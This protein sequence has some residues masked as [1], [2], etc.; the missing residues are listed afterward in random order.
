MPSSWERVIYSGTF[1]HAAVQEQIDEIAFPRPVRATALR[2][3]PLYVTDAAV[4]EA[5]S[6]TF[7]GF[8]SPGKFALDVFGFD[9]REGDDGAP[10]ASRASRLCP[11][12]RFESDGKDS[13]CVR[14]DARA[15]DRIV[16]RGKFRT[17][18]LVVI[19]SPLEES[20]IEGCAFTWG[21]SV[22]VAPKPIAAAMEVDADDVGGEAVAAAA[23]RLISGEEAGRASPDA[24]SA[25]LAH[26]ESTTTMTDEGLAQLKSAA[27]DCLSDGTG[28][29]LQEAICAPAIAERAASLLGA[30][31]GA[32][33]N[34]RCAGAVVAAL[35]C[36]APRT[37]ALFAEANGVPHLLHALGPSQGDVSM[38]A[39]VAAE[40]ASRHSA[41]LAALAS[42]DGM[43][44]ALACVAIN[45][46][47]SPPDP[48]PV[49]A[50]QRVQFA[51]AVSALSRA[52][53]AGGKGR[54]A[55]DALVAAAA[56]LPPA[57][58]ALLG[59][60]PSSGPTGNVASFDE[61]SAWER[62]RATL[63]L[64]DGGEGG[65]GAGG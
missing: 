10:V 21:R 22:S 29:S 40:R 31:A 42:T 20:A 60:G 8:T 50:L 35:L 57:L 3:V 33:P 25:A 6:R 62:E 26:F 53:K 52:A 63:P 61:V 4:A 47:R 49:L 18:S 12:I 23:A 28:A 7:S 16:V 5:E 46:L 27:R 37:F 19:G 51:S 24:M 1:R 30:G 13:F 38:W 65:G 32:G 43:E 41:G 2:I 55:R 15:V 44:E 14:V 48:Q 56:A 39:A 36:A 9:A 58:G 54:R 34:D 59:P 64:L 11:T 17:L 45:P